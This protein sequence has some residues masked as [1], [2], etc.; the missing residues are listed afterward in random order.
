MRHSTPAELAALSG[1]GGFQS[2]RCRHPCKGRPYVIS[3]AHSFHMSRSQSLTDAA[4]SRK[5]TEFLLSDIIGIAADAIICLDAEQRITLYNDGAAK[6]FGWTA[7][8]IMGQP[9]NVLI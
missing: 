1:V 2:D 5:L 8:E 9:L 3:A 7:D 4:A 6:I